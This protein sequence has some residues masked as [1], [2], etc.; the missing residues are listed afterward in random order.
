MGL[1]KKFLRTEARP[2]NEGDLNH[3]ASNAKNKPLR[4]LIKRYKKPIGFTFSKELNRVTNNAIFP[5]K[6]NVQ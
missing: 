3:K 1:S 5:R 4:T 2:K 6:N